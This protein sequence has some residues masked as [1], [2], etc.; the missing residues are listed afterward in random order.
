M[1]NHNSLNSSVQTPSQ[2][3][4]DTWRA[5]RLAS[6][7]S[8]TGNLALIETRWYPPEITLEEA[9]IG[10]PKTVTTTRTKQTDFDG[11]VIQ[12][13]IRLWDSNSEG[14]QA[15]ETIDVYPFDPAWTFEATFTPH[16]EMRPVPFEYVR[17]TP[18]TRNLA[19]PGEIKVAIGGVEYA[20]DAFDDDDTLLLVFADPTN[21][22]ETYPAGRFLFVDTEEETDRV[23]IDF[24]RAF[25]P[26]CG[27]SLAYNCPLPPPQNRLQ[28]PVYAGE[29]KPIFRNNYEIH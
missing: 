23:V 4:W 6:V 18:E 16:A 3:D 25:V 26:P 7:V 12:R 27:F 1:V 13:G 9:L 22:T 20:L 8:P 10:Q 15:F 11:N 5:R 21:R 29:K 19:V 24:N 14:I 17:E 28:V 2:A